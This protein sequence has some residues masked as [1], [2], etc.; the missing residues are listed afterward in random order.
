[1]CRYLMPEMYAALAREAADPP[2]VDE[3]P[4]DEQPELEEIAR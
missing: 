1:M 2:D 4:T 3:P